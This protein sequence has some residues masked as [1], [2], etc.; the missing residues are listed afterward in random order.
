MVV[1]LALAFAFLALAGIAGV[2]AAATFSARLPGRLLFSWTAAEAGCLAADGDCSP[3]VLVDEAASAPLS[4]RPFAARL[5]DVLQSPASAERQALA[6]QLLKRN[7]RS[8]A[9]RLVLSEAA[10]AAGERGRFL[11][12]FLPVFDI[13]RARSAAYADALANLSADPEIR[14]G[15]AARLEASPS[16]SNAYLSALTR[17]G[18]MPAGDLIPLLRHVPAAQAPF[19]ARLVKQGSWDVAYAAFAE[20]VT[21]TAGAG[22]ALLTTPFNP[23]LRAQAAPAPFNW[24]LVSHSAQFLPEGGVY[25]FYEGRKPQVLL[26]QSFPLGPGEYEL[27]TTQSGE[28]SETGGYFRWQAACA[29]GGAAI[30]TF[31]VKSLKAAPERAAYAFA[32]APDACGF[33]TLSLRGVPGAFPRPARIEV[34]SVRISPVPAQENAP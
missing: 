33:V 25:A 24:Q 21:A 9:A 30:A 27:T 4:F 28:A 12:V 20:F 15:L 13:D 1:R 31:D 8:A 16:W 3:A 6:E 34:S 19:L 32:A 22:P 5:A 29:E 10:L 14:S 2:Y 11:S 7:P 17:R 26:A 23:D 18:G